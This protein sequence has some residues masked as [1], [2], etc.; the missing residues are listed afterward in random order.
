MKQILR[1]TIGLTISCLIAGSIMGLVFTITA[2][3]K[4]HNEHLN[5]QETMLALL[6][7]TKANPA[8]SD[9]RFHSVYRYIIEDGEAKYIGYMVPVKKGAT[10]GYEL[11]VINLAGKFVEKLEVP[12]SPEAAIEE[13]ERETALKTV[14]RHPKTFTY[15]DTTIIARLGDKQLAYLLPGEFPGFKTFISVM[16]ALDPNFKILGLE[17][18]EHEEDPGLGAEIEQE[19]FKNQF[20]GKSFEKVKRLKVIKEPLPD[21][22]KRYLETKKWKK[23]MFSEQEIE[24]IRS[25]Y[26]DHDIYALTGATISSRSVTNGV[27][28]I[29]KKFAYRMGKLNKVIAS[30]HIAVTF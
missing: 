29:I 8:P 2:K 22:Y 11:V 3:A 10:E 5:V 9:L 24:S 4:K 14:L 20:K 1:I 26:Q 6:G 7:Y 28:N 13:G 23:G 12:I 30:Q 19:Y 15:A 27:K 25:K 16:L 18:M 17:I 21:K